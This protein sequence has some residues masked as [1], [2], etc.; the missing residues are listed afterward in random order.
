MTIQT[1]ANLVRTNDVY[2]SDFFRHRFKTRQMRVFLCGHEPESR[3]NDPRHVLK[4]ILED[5]FGCNGFLGEEIPEISPDGYKPSVS[6]DHL[7]IEV[8]WAE[9][10]DLIIM[11]LG[12]PG[13]IAELTAFALNDNVNPK[14]LVFNHSE[15]RNVKSFISQ[16]PLKLLQAEQRQFYESDA[17][18]LAESS[19][20]AIDVAVSQAWHRSSL[21]HYDS[22]LSSYHS[23]MALCVIYSLFPVTY[24]SLK[25]RMPW[26]EKKLLNALGSLNDAGLITKKGKAF[27]PTVFL[28]DSILPTDMQT[29]VSAARARSLSALVADDDFLRKYERKYNGLRGAGRFRTAL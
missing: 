20:R 7:T 14:L 29:D 4:R 25:N 17:A 19:I 11:F 2:L 27:E 3:H 23:L 15:F 12:S 18:L 16:G 28:R 5:R 24:A 9:D 22:I 26:S 6:Q 8:K 13:T 1:A 10:S 21:S